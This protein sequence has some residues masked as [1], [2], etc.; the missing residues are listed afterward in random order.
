[1]IK[2]TIKPFL[3]WAGGKQRS[4]EELFLHRPRDFSDKNRYY[5]PFLGAGS[6]F[7]RLSPKKATLTDI[8]SDLVQCYNAIKGNPKKIF[9]YLDKHANNN[10]EK[11][12][13]EMRN[14][15][16]NSRASYKRAALFI[17]LN[18]ACFNGIWRVN[19]KGKF[20]VPY[21]QKESPALPTEQKLV[22]ISKKLKNVSIIDRDYQRVLTYAKEGDL[23]YFD[24]PY[25]SLNGN[26]FVKYTKNGF[27]DEDHK[28]L[29]C[30]AE[31]LSKRGCFV[32]ISNADIPKIRRIYRKGFHMN[33]L[34]VTH[35]INANGNRKKVNEVI[36]TNYKVKKNRKLDDFND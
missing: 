36:I 8:N 29:V 18:K 14:V 9:E 16:N 27:N 2:I 31:E 15:F 4:V 21:G 35:F 32:M 19:Q 1:M 23:I 17:Y 22:E 5:E 28:D 13:Y 30:V 33:T 24:P 20:N 25:P 6:F 7:F 3:R 11:Y 26:G 12:Y 34:K 10:C